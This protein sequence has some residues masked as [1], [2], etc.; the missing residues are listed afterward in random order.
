MEAAAQV[1]VDME[2]FEALVD[3]QIELEA[4]PMGVQEVALDANAECE[5]LWASGTSTDAAMDP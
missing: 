5:E 3:A 1:T 2:A 4:R